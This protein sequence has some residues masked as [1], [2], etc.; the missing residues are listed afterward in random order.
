MIGNI[1][2][3]YGCYE[4][5]NETGVYIEDN[6]PCDYTLVMGYSNRQV[7]Y[8]PSIAACEYG[9][10]EADTTRFV[11]GTA[12]ICADKLLAL[13]GELKQK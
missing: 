5:F 6:S 1:G 7:G 3:V 8:M 4:M 2:F 12:E 9:C 13:L 10:Y 11:K